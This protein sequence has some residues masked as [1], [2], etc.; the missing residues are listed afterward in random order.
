MK[1]HVISL[2]Q[3]FRGKCYAWDVVNEV[4]NDDGTLR[5]SLWSRTIGPAFIPIAFA[6]AAGA[7]PDAKLYINEYDIE[8]DYG[9]RS[10]GKGSYFSAPPSGSGSGKTK[11]KRQTTGICK[12]CGRRKIEGLKEVVKLVRANGAKVDGVGFQSH[13]EYDNVPSA[14]TLGR[15]MNEFSGMGLDTAI[16]ELDIRMN[17]A[18]NGFAAQQEQGNGY[19]GVVRACKNVGRCVGV[20]IWEFSDYWGWSE[21]FLL[22]LVLMPVAGII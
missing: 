13:F 14:D 18:N 10:V 15:I 21:Y 3:H 16:T 6:A 7:D 1:A 20:T 2:V 12:D 9:I 22:F 19:E 17:L 11:G 5:D 8:N 4:L